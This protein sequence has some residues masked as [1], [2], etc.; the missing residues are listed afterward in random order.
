MDLDAFD[1]KLLEALQR[2]S[3]RPNAELGALVGLSASQI[4]RRRERL[5]KAG[6]IRAYRADVDGAK[7]GYQLTVFIHVTLAAHSAGNAKKLRDLV[8]T[9]PQIQEAHAMT[10]ETDYLFR[11]AVAGLA[12]LAAFVNER[13]LAHPAIAR[14]RSEIVLE[15]LKDQR[16]WIA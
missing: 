12:E 1:F 16:I 15:T 3:A 14:V 7:L 10:G 5:E 4:S 13:L 2:D 8:L 11:V 6:V 9:T